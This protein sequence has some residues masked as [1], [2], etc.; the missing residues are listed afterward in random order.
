MVGRAVRRRP[1]SPAPG[2]PRGADVNTLVPGVR[3]G[4]SFL[5][6]RNPVAKFV[7][8]FAVSAALL[9]VFDPA[10]PALLYALALLAV[11][12]LGRVGMRVLAAAQLPFFAFAVSLLAVN[13]VSRGGTVI[14]SAGW[15][16][17]TDDGLAV[18]TSLALRTMVI[19]TC[20]VG[21][22]LTTDPV[23]LLTSMQRQLRLPPQVAY[24]MLAGYRLLGMLPGE[25][26]SIRRAHAVRQP[27]T[28]HGRA[29][30][31]PRALARAAITLLVLALRRG[32]RLAVALESR[33]LGAGE[34]TVWRPVV[35]TG[36]DVVFLVAVALVVA[37]TFAVT[38]W[39]GLLRGPGAL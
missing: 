29:P 32:E 4:D 14:V 33:G 31:T 10:T 3:D 8:V 15:F 17:I 21:F 7:A 24:G 30:R 6:R 11:G 27:R 5:H 38:A 22:V 34:R 20:S 37:G 35:V 18:G 13:A 39:A 25:W 19:G 26:R 16:S 12:V 9:G 1:A 23:R 28:R 2:A 36:G